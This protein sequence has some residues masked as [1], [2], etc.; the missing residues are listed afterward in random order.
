[1]SEKLVIAVGST[2]PV[3]VAASVNG[4]KRA[5]QLLGEV[6]TEKFNVPSGVSDQPMTDAETKAGAQNRAKAAY[7][8]YQRAHDGIAPFL[9]VGLEGGVQ[10]CDNSE[11]ECFAWIAVYNGTQTGFARTGSFVLPRRI[12]DLVVDEGMELG[13]AD[14]L[15]FGAT[16]SKQSSGAVGF[17]TNGVID[18]AAYYEHAVILACIPFQRAEL[19]V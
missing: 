1:M 17:L 2:N 6:S 4:V 15:V 12:R 14:D 5:F 18:R 11:L 16:N 9:S 10:Q 19:Y 7:A 3:K 8:A 13:H